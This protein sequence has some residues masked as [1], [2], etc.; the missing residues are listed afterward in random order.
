MKTK[1]KVGDRIMLTKLRPSDK[2]ALKVGEIGT[3][4]Y[5]WKDPS[6]L[7]VKWDI[8]NKHKHDCDGEGLCRAGHGWN[9]YPENT[10]KIFKNISKKE[11]N[12]L[13]LIYTVL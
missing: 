5:V 6:Y 7:G 2:P 11:L 4:V 12:K 10:I 1:L 3:I 9:V 13:K 8:Y